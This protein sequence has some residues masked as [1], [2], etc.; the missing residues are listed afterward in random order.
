MLKE[1][2]KDEVGRE[3]LD[4]IITKNTTIEQVPEVK[5]ELVL[6]GGAL[7]LH[8]SKKCLLVLMPVCEGSKSFELFNR[9]REYSSIINKIYDCAYICPQ[10]SV[11]S[12]T[13][14][15]IPIINDTTTLNC[16]HSSI[17]MY[18]K[19]INVYAIDVIGC[20]SDEASRYLYRSLFYGGYN[21]VYFIEDLICNDESLSIFQPS[22]FSG[23]DPLEIHKVSLATLANINHCEQFSKRVTFSSYNSDKDL[24]ML[25]DSGRIKPKSMEDIVS[26][27][28]QEIK[29]VFIKPDTDKLTFSY[30][31]MDLAFKRSCLLEVI[32][33]MRRA[34]I[35]EKQ[36]KVII[37][38][39]FSEILDNIIK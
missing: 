38:N 22:D 32:A 3:L 20:I 17:C 5:D 6:N 7:D 16:K 21:M 36:I 37:K 9:V 12:K 26:E 4:S 18:L 31:A 23:I 34:G 30:D 25:F 10:D 14:M 27:M 29:E 11:N 15:G 35:S 28:D 24:N 13:Y 2:S 39:H 19:R 33:D 8:S 1:W